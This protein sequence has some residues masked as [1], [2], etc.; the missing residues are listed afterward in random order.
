MRILQKTDSESGTLRAFLEKRHSIVFETLR[1]PQIIETD[2]SSAGEMTVYTWRRP[3]NG[4]R[5]WAIQVELFTP[6]DVQWW[7]TWVVD[8]EPTDEQIRT[9][10]GSNAEDGSVL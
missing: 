5:L 9:I 1:K 4:E 6:P 2:S 7:R 10:L 3:S 8:A